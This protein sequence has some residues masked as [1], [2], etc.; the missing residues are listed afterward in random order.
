MFLAPRP[1]L[2]SAPGPWRLHRHKT[3][4]LSPPIATSE[5][6]ECGTEWRA[7]L[8]AQCLWRGVH[9]GTG[10]VDG[11]NTPL[12]APDL[13][14]VFTFSPCAGFS[15]QSRSAG[16][17]R[18][19]LRGGAPGRGGPLGDAHELRGCRRM[20]LGLHQWQVTF[21]RGQMLATERLRA[22]CK[23]R[24]GNHSNCLVCRWR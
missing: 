20:A 3:T 9:L 15:S 13:S 14:C 10:Q 24:R 4:L 8:A 5:S 19:H 23:R 7:R 17:W 1:P 22:V 18:P 11:T 21:T 12:S 16:S 2:G 6:Q